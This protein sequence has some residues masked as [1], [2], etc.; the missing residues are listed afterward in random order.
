[1][2]FDTVIERLRPHW[3]TDEAPYLPRGQGQW[4]PTDGAGTAIVAF[5]WG[6]HRESML[7]ALVLG[8]SLR[9]VDTRADLV[10]AVEQDT[11]SDETTGWAPLLK[12]L[13]KHRDAGL[14]L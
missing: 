13:T 9:R 11:L 14:R 6:S 1:M 5:V 8:M 12:A 10:L 2:S 3:D 4:A 7:Q